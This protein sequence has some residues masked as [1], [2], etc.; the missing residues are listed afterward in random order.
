MFY[1]NVVYSLSADVTVNAASEQ[2]NLMVS[3][4]DEDRRKKS[5]YKVKRNR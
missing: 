5:A 2:D 4:S 1:E 3:E